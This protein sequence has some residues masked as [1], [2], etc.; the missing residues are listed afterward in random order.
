MQ[1]I[2]TTLRSH[3][4]HAPRKTTEFR[5][6][7]VG[8]DVEFL[9]GVLSRNQCGGV[10]RRQ[11]DRSAIDIGGILIGDTAANLVVAEAPNTGER[12][13]VLIRQGTALRGSLRNHS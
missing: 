5:A 2:R 8:G 7:V 1:R 13:A 10:V 3:V 6:D 4:D 9:N 12:A 11:V